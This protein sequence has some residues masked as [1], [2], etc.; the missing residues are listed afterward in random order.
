MVELC[1]KG[2]T[3]IT[4]NNDSCRTE[5]ELHNTK[6]VS[7]DS[8]TIKLDTGGYKTNTTKN[9]M[10]LASQ[11]YNLDYTV[12]QKKGIWYVIYK[13]ETIEFIGNTVTLTRFLTS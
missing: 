6:I 4:Y 2:N 1:K 3:R 5:I 12:F 7:F 9:R 10:N 8:E 11:E 13:G